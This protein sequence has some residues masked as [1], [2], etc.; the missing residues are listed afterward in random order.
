MNGIRWARKDLAQVYRH[1][2]RNGIKSPLGK[3][4]ISLTQQM[5]RLIL[6]LIAAWRVDLNFTI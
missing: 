4:G 3:F 1:F 5:H 2:N 6:I